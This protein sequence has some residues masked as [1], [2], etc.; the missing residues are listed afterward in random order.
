MTKSDI[1]QRYRAWKSSGYAHSQP[2]F[3]YPGNVV[4]EQ[5]V[6]CPSYPVGQGAIVLGRITS[7]GR[8]ERYAASGQVS[9]DPLVH[10]GPD[11]RLAGVC[12]QARCVHWSGS[13]Q[14][15]AAIIAPSENLVAIADCHIRARCRWYLE[16]G[17]SACVTCDHVAYKMEIAIPAE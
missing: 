2:P 4:G 16:H 11:L 1:A 3:P 12:H 7:E 14:L 10:V 17:P 9:H 13:C 15:A 5:R 8:L 6:L